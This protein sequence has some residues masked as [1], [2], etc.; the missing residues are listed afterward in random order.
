MI[1]SAVCPTANRAAF[2]SHVPSSSRCETEIIPRSS[3][4]V[5]TTALMNCPSVNRSRGC[6]M[7]ETEMQS[8]DSSD[9]MPQPT[10]TNAPNGSRCVTRASM[11]SPLVSARM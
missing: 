3:S 4:G 7:R 8:M 1:P 11:T 2:S 6:E 10:S 9:A 5:R